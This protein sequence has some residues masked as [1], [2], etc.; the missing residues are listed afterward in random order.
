MKKT[1]SRDQ[2]ST[3]HT[4]NNDDKMRNLR[5]LFLNYMF[6]YLMECETL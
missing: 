1:T 3:T 2:T 4:K 6:R 5:N